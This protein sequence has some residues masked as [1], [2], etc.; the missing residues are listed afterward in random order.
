MATSTVAPYLGHAQP[1]AP[2][3]V[4]YTP[5]VL[6]IFIAGILHSPMLC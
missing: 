2:G 1:N 3:S 5:G 4:I 6:V